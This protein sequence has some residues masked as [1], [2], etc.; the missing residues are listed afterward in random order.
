MKTD[1]IFFD[2]NRKE[3]TVDAIRDKAIENQ[4]CQLSTK[5]VSFSARHTIGMSKI[6]GNKLNKLIA[7]GYSKEKKDTGRFKVQQ[8]LTNDQHTVVNDKKTGRKIVVFKGTNPGN[9]NDLVSDASLAIGAE[10]NNKRFQNSRSFLDKVR[11]SSKR[12]G[13][14]SKLTVIGHSLGGSLA[15]YAGN[16]KKDTV[17]TVNKGSGVRQIGKKIPGNQTDI[18]SRFD[19][20][21]AMSLFNKGPGKKVSTGSNALNQFIGKGAHNFAAVK[22]LNS[23]AIKNKPAAKSKK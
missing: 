9:L 2:V 12:A 21:S 1:C 6:S 15:E 14:G 11:E 8:N 13:S 10:K 7:L 5:H 22:N 23:K 20:V 17:I 3:R 19:A 4:S 16:R 18:R